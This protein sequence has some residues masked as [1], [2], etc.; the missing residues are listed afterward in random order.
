MEPQ[1]LYEDVLTRAETLPLEELSRLIGEL[2]KFL[3]EKYG[4][5][6]DLKGVEE[7]RNYIEWIRFRDSHYPDGR[8][9][10][11]EEFLTELGEDE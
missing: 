9:K 4:K 7:V 6:T 11:P 1:R 2:S 5:W 3:Y 10:S 8:Q